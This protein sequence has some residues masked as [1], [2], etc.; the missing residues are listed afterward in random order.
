ML[1]TSELLSRAARPDLYRVNAF[2]V[3]QLHAGA[4]TRELTRRVERIKMIAKLGGPSQGPT[5]PLPLQ[6]A[7]DPETVREALERLRDPEVRLLDE[8]FWFWPQR[9]DGPA[10]ELALGAL[11]HGN[12]A[13]ARRLWQ[14]ALQPTPQPAALHNLAVLAHLMALDLEHRAQESQTP[15]DSFTARLRDQSWAAAF[16]HWAALLKLEEFWQRLRAR[17]VQLAEPQLTPDLA[18]AMRAELPLTLLSI[19]AQLAVAAAARGHA[20]EANRHRQIVCGSGL[21]DID[22]EQALRRA[23]KP[24]RERLRSLSQDG[25]QGQADGWRTAVELYQRVVGLPLTQTD[26]DTL[27]DDVAEVLKRVCWFC[28]KR[29]GESGTASVVWLHCRLTRTKTAHGESVH[30]HRYVVDV[31]RC[32]HCYQEHRRWELSRAMGTLPRGVRPESDGAAFPTIERLKA[33]G[34]EIGAIPP[35]I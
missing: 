12:V 32:W 13:A 33:E 5:G 1:R 4:T 17:I 20:E 21:D 15:L 6:P 22:I 23:L 34:W 9:F 24:V 18:D 25:G 35:G 26:R 31:P 19:N 29:V 30:W 3:A 14:D 28:Q 16:Q 11:A 10:E 8:F 2:R 7:P 27:L